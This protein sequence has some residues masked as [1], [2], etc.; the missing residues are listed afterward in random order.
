M[1]DYLSKEIGG[2]EADDESTSDRGVEGVV[3]EQDDGLARL[4]DLRVTW[5]F[6]MHAILPERA[7]RRP[8]PPVMLATGQSRRW[9]RLKGARW[10]PPQP[11]QEGPKQSR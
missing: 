2:L 10:T 4:N 3:D 11:R 1:H 5:G 7:H 6:N 8:L 9:I